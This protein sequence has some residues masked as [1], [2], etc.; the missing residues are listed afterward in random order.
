V[1]LNRLVSDQYPNTI[2]DVIY[3]T[4]L[5]RAVKT[6]GKW[7]EENFDPYIAVDA[8]MYGPYILPEDICFYSDWEKGQEVWGQLGKYTFA[9]H[10]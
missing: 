8:A 1:V 4:E 2:R 6:M 10:R 5:Y 7:G 3:E 9:K